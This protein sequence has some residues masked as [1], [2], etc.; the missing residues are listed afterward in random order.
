MFIPLAWFE[1]AAFYHSR[2]GQSA[3]LT[4]FPTQ[5]DRRAWDRRASQIAVENDRR[6][7][8]RRKVEFRA[9]VHKIL[10][11]YFSPSLKEEFAHA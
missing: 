1:R 3:V 10:G 5:V 9:L 8:D 11:D 2:T 4:A 7:S 6:E